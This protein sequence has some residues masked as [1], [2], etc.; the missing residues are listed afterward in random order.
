VRKRDE[1]AC[2]T[3]CRGRR[4]LALLCALALG[5]SASFGCLNP[6]P[7]E[8]PSSLESAPD[9]DDAARQSGPTTLDAPAGGNAGDE[10]SPQDQAPRPTAAEAPPPPAEEDAPVGDAG[11]E[12][13]AGSDSDAGAD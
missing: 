11:V 4:R 1:E 7:E 10:A 6:R 13:D 5:C 9:T 12:V 3:S 8:L 2:E